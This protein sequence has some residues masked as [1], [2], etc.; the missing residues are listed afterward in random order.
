MD[1]MSKELPAGVRDIPFLQNIQTVSGPTQPPISYS[2][3][4]RALSLGVKC[5]GCEDDHTS[6]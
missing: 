2:V 1:W 6:H 3:V 5:P 4:T